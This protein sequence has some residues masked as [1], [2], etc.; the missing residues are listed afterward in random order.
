[1][2]ESPIIFEIM[3]VDGPHIYNRD[4]NGGYYA[5]DQ[6]LDLYSTYIDST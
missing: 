4:P 6:R 5:T 1:M 3:G 2:S